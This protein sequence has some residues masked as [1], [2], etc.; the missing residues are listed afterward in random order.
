M[1]HAVAHAVANKSRVTVMLGFLSL[2]GVLGPWA[3]PGAGVGILCCFSCI[4]F[5]S[6]SLSL[7]WLSLVSF[8]VLVVVCLGHVCNVAVIVVYSVLVVFVI[9][10]LLFSSHL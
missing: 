8:V 3:G 9:I 10:H 4:V 6:T 1:V 2:D 7:L 5:M